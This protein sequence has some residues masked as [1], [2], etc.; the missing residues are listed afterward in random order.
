MANNWHNWEAKLSEKIAAQADNFAKIKQYL[1]IGW[2]YTFNFLKKGAYWSA[3]FVVG[4]SLSGVI[5]HLAGIP[6]FN[7]AYGATTWVFMIVGTLVYYLLVA[8]MGFFT[9]LI[10]FIMQLVINYPWGGLWA[11]S[12]A[13]QAA[14][15]GGFVN[16]QAV[17]TGW[18]LV[19]DVSNLFFSIILVVI[20][21]GTVLKIEAYSWKKL[22]PKFILMAVLINFS[23]SICG[24]FTDVATIAMATFGGAF[25]EKFAAGAIGAFGLP[26]LTDY[27]SGEVSSDFTGSSQASALLAYFASGM[28]MT[29]AFVVFLIFTVILIFRIAMLWFLIV[30]SPLAYLTRILPLTEKYSQQWWKMFGGYVMVGPIVTF[31]LWLSLTL[32][33]GGGE[34]GGE[35]G[36]FQQK[37]SNDAAI[38]SYGARA[39]TTQSPKTGGGNFQSTTPNVLANFLITTMLLMA[40]LKQIKEMASE[41]SAITGKLEGMAWSAGTSLLEKGGRTLAQYS[42]GAGDKDGTFGQQVKYR[43]GQLGTFAGATVLQPVSFAKGLTEQLKRSSEEKKVRASDIASQKADTM[44]KET[45]RGAGIINAPLAALANLGGIVMGLGMDNGKDVWENTVSGQGAWRIGKKGWDMSQRKY[46]KLED[47][48]KQIGAKKTELDKDDRLT[49]E[50]K[51]EKQQEYETL[52]QR[53]GSIATDIAGVGDESIRI[54][55]DNADFSMA[56]QDTISQLEQDRDKDLAAGQTGAAA[57]KQSQIGLLNEAIKAGGQQDALDEFCRTYDIDGDLKEKLKSDI[58]SNL[59]GSKEAHKDEREGIQKKLKASGYTFLSDGKI[60][61]WG[62]DTVAE[63]DRQA[64]E[65]ALNK[66]EKEAQGLQN[67]LA[68]NEAGVSYEGRMSTQTLVNEELKKLQDVKNSDEI[69]S[70]LERGIEQN[71][72]YLVEAVLQRLTQNGDENELFQDYMAKYLETNKDDSKVDGIMK[73]YKKKTGEKMEASSGIKG[74]HA[75]RHLILKGK[76]GVDDQASMRIMNDVTYTAEGI[77]HNGVARGYKMVGG[78]FSE[79]TAKQQAN[80]VVVEKMKQSPNDYLQWNRLGWG[81]ED[82]NRHFQVSESGLRILQSAAS[83]MEDERLWNRFNTNA[84]MNLSQPHVLRELRANGVDKKFCNKLETYWRTTGQRAAQQQGL[85]MRL[86]A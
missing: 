83:E 68:A 81:D 57:T 21:I 76:M 25:G 48:Q 12:S 22:L 20:A 16:V 10:A 6:I 60:D 26:T 53:A 58:Q 13:G 29:V 72:Q 8:P 35:G 84:K 71:N 82:A 80:A 3:V 54:D 11:V 5:M 70:F 43:A 17:V 28:M 30:L 1:A 59:E 67:M 18:R 32:A 64:E 79:L 44:S 41:A 9:V 42:A 23:K 65:Q 77:G 75:F 50:E 38:T 56:V 15:T 2:K 55:M 86:A 63:A 7:V 74:M 61:A 49:T 19:R 40:S 46:K 62:I 51:E 27:V 39:G 4:L 85:H 52:L 45:V 37:M 36:G 33:Y 66:L 47:L 24:I 73:A 78:V 14:N 69:M 34:V 31:F